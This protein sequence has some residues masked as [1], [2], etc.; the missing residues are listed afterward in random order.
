MKLLAKKNIEIGNGRNPNKNGLLRLERL[1]IPSVGKQKLG[2]NKW[3]YL[4]IFLLLYSNSLLCGLFCIM[5]VQCSDRGEVRV[6]YEI[7]D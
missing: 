7:T 5:V 3:K 6:N 4:Y 1:K 2:E